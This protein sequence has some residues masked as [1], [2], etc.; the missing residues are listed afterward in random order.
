MSIAVGTGSP[1]EFHEFRKETGGKKILFKMSPTLLPDTREETA[2]V[3]REKCFFSIWKRENAFLREGAVVEVCAVNKDSGVTSYTV[4]YSLPEG[5][6]TKNV[7]EVPH[8]CASIYKS[9]QTE[10]DKA[11]VHFKDSQGKA[12]SAS[13]HPFSITQLAT[14]DE[15]AACQK[16]C[17]SKKVTFDYAFDANTTE[18]E[19]FPLAICN[20]MGSALKEGMSIKV[21]KDR[22]GQPS[23][24][25]AG[26]QAH[27]AIRCAVW[28]VKPVSAN[29]TVEVT[30]TVQ[31]GGV[32]KIEFYTPD[33]LAAFK[34]V[35]QERRLTFVHSDNSVRGE[36]RDLVEYS[37]WQDVKNR[38][39]PHGATFVIYTLPNGTYSYYNAQP[40]V[41]VCNAHP[42]SSVDRT[43]L[44]GQSEWDQVFIKHA[45]L[46]DGHRSRALEFVRTTPDG[47]GYL[48]RPTTTIW[49]ETSPLYNQRKVS[50]S[51]DRFD[52]YSM[53]RHAAERAKASPARVELLVKAG[54]DCHYYTAPVNKEARAWADERGLFIQTASNYSFQGDRGFLSGPYES[55]A[56]MGILEHLQGDQHRGA[57][58]IFEGV[59]DDGYIYSLSSQ[60]E[61]AMEGGVNEDYE[62]EA[63]NKGVSFTI[64]SRAPYASRGYEEQVLSALWKQLK[65]DP[66]LTSGTHIEVTGFPYEGNPG[67]ITYTR[68]YEGL[69]A[70]AKVV[71]VAPPA[72]GV[73]RKELALFAGIQKQRPLEKVEKG[74]PPEVYTTHQVVLKQIQIITFESTLRQIL[75]AIYHFFLSLYSQVF[76]AQDHVMA[77]TL[78]A[79]KGKGGSIVNHA[80]MLSHMGLMQSLLEKSGLTEISTMLKKAQESG[81]LL[82]QAALRHDEASMLDFHAE[83]FSFKNRALYNLSKIRTLLPCVKD[84]PKVKFCDYAKATIH[85]QI[86][87]ALQENRSFLL[88]VGMGEKEQYAPHFLLFSKDEQGHTLVKDIRLSPPHLQSRYS[89]VVTHD[90]G[91]MN[92]GDFVGHLIALQPQASQ[93][94]QK[95]GVAAKRIDRSMEAFI[96][97]QIEAH[98][99]TK[100]DARFGIKESHQESTLDPWALF[101]SAL[102]EANFSMTNPETQEKF[103]AVL[104]SKATFMRHYVNHLVTFLDEHEG[105]FSTQEKIKVLESIK[106]YAGQLK[107]LLAEELGNQGVLVAGEIVDALVAKVSFRLEEENRT[108]EM[109]SVEV[110]NLEHE[111][112]LFSLNLQNAIDATMDAQPVAAMQLNKPRPFSLPAKTMLA[113]AKLPTRLGAQATKEERTEVLKD[114]Q[115]HAKTLNDMLEAG[116]AKQAKMVA[117]ALLKTFPPATKESGEKTFWDTLSSKEE[118]KAWSD[119]L[120][121]VSERF[122]EAALQSKQHPLSPEE[123]FY[124]NTVTKLNMLHLYDRYVT[125]FPVLFDASITGLTSHHSVFTDLFHIK[126]VYLSL[127]GTPLYKGSKAAELENLQGMDSTIIDNTLYGC[128]NDEKSF[129]QFI[130]ELKARLTQHLRGVFVGEMDREVDSRI[131]KVVTEA[132]LRHFRHITETFVNEKLDRLDNNELCAHVGGAQQT[133]IAHLTSEKGASP[134]ANTLDTIQRSF[135]VGINYRERRRALTDSIMGKFLTPLRNRA[136]PP[137]AETPKARSEQVEDLHR[138]LEGYLNAVLQDHQNFIKGDLESI[139]GRLPDSCS[140]FFTGQVVSME[141]Q[142]AGMQRVYSL[143]HDLVV[144][145]KVAVRKKELERLEKQW[146]AEDKAETDS[147]KVR[148]KAI[149]DWTK[150]DKLVKKNQVEFAAYKARMEAYYAQ[151]PGQRRGSPPSYPWPETDNYHDRLTKF[152]TKPEQIAQVEARYVPLRET[153]QKDMAQYDAELERYNEYQRDLAAHQREM[154]YWRA[155][156]M[157]GMRNPSPPEPPQ[158]PKAVDMPLWTNTRFG[159]YAYHKQYGG[160]S[161]LARLERRK[162]DEIADIQ[163]LDKPTDGA[164]HAV[165]LAHPDPVCPDKIIA[166]NRSELAIE[167]E[168]ELQK[169]II[170]ALA[171]DGFL[172][173]LPQFKVAQMGKRDFWFDTAHRYSPQMQAFFGHVARETGMSTEHYAETLYT[174]KGGLKA[175]LDGSTRNEAAQRIFMLDDNTHTALTSRPELAQLRKDCAVMVAK[176]EADRRPA[177]TS[178]ETR[179][180]FLTGYSKKGDWLQPLQREGFTDNISLLL[181]NVKTDDAAF[182]HTITLCATGY[183]FTDE[184][185]SGHLASTLLSRLKRRDA[186][187]ATLESPVAHLECYRIGQVSGAFLDFT[188]ASPTSASL[189]SDLAGQRRIFVR[190]T[191]QKATISHRTGYEKRAF[192]LSGD[193]TTASGDYCTKPDDEF[194][195]NAKT[196]LRSGF[197]GQ[198]TTPLVDDCLVDDGERTKALESFALHTDTPP[199]SDPNFGWGPKERALEAAAASR[200]RLKRSGDRALG[201]NAMREFLLRSVAVKDGT[202]AASATDHPFTWRSVE[203]A[204]EYI[205]QFPD[206]LVH[207]MTGEEV[208]HKLL[209]TVLQ[210][211]LIEKALQHNPQFFIDFAAHLE[212]NRLFYDQKKNSDKKEG[213]PEGGSRFDAGKL[214]LFH[215]GEKICQVATFLKEKGK[216]SDAQH[217][218]LTQ[219]LP[220]HAVYEAN[221]VECTWSN[222]GM[223]QRLFAVYLL[224]HYR[225]CKRVLTRDDHVQLLKAHA[226]I[227]QNPSEMGHSGHLTEAEHAFYMTHL[228]MLEES[229]DPEKEETQDFLTSL[230][231]G[232]RSSHSPKWTRVSEYVYKLEEVGGKSHTLDLS[233]G[234][235]L[236]IATNMDK[237]GGLPRDVLEHPDYKFLFGDKNLLVQPKDCGDGLAEY[238]WQEHGTDIRYLIRFQKKNEKHTVSHCQIFQKH[239]YKSKEVLYRFTRLQQDTSILGLSFNQNN[240]KI[241]ELIARR[242]AW[243]RLNKAG[244]PQTDHVYLPQDGNNIEKDP[245]RLHIRSSKITGATV[246]EGN[247][248]KWVVSSLAS[249][250]AHLLPFKNLDNMLLLSSDRRHVDEIRFFHPP[251]KEPAPDNNAEPS[252]AKKKEPVKDKSGIGAENYFLTLRR[253]PQNR[254]QWDVANREGWIWQLKATAH[255]EKQFGRNYREN[256][257]HLMNPKTGEEE[258]W[259]FPYVVTGT[260]QKGSDVTYMKK[261]MDF[262]DLLE[263][264]FGQ[265]GQTVN[266]KAEVKAM[267]DGILKDALKK[268]GDFDAGR[269]DNRPGTMDLARIA[270]YDLYQSFI[271]QPFEFIRGIVGVGSEAFSTKKME[272]AKRI[273]QKFGSSEQEKEEIGKK[274]DESFGQ[275]RG[276][277][278]GFFKDI[279]SPRA[280]K[281]SKGG[282][283]GNHASFFYLA[284]TASL[285]GDW[286]VASDYLQRMTQFGDTKTAEELEQLEYL[287]T[288]VL[289]KDSLGQFVQGQLA[290]PATLEHSAFQLKMLTSLKMV[291]KRLETQFHRPV[292]NVLLQMATRLGVGKE[293]DK[294]AA[295]ASTMNLSGG[296][297]EGVSG[298]MFECIYMASLVHTYN[299][300][301][302]TKGQQLEALGLLLTREERVALRSYVPVDMLSFIDPQ[303]PFSL[304]KLAGTETVEQV[305]QICSLLGIYDDKSVVPDTQNFAI[306]TKEEV[307]RLM[308]SVA[309]NINPNQ[310]VDIVAL[311]K[312]EGS[313]P[314]WETVVANFYS[315]I[316]WIYTHPNLKASELSFLLADIPFLSKNREDVDIARRLIF[317]FYHHLHTSGY[318]QAEHNSSTNSVDFERAL[319][320]VQALAA[321]FPDLAKQEENIKAYAKQMG[322]HPSFLRTAKFGAYRFWGSLR[323]WLTQ[324]EDKV[325]VGSKEYANRGHWGLFQNA[326]GAVLF[327]HVMDQLDK[328]YTTISVF[329]FGKGVVGERAL[330]MP[331]PKYA[332]VSLGSTTPGLRTTLVPAPMGGMT[333]G[334]AGSPA[335]DDSV[336]RAATAMMS[337]LDQTVDPIVGALLPG[338]PYADMAKGRI[339]DSLNNFL[340]PA[341]KLLLINPDFEGAYTRFTGVLAQVVEAF[342]A[343]S[344]KATTL[345]QFLRSG[346]T[347]STDPIIRP[348]VPTVNALKEDFRKQHTSYQQSLRQKSSAAAAATTRGAARAA[349]PETTIEKASTAVTGRLKSIVDG[350]ISSLSFL[351]KLGMSTAINKELPALVKTLL[352]A[353]DFEAAYPQFKAGLTDVIKAYKSDTGSLATDLPASEPLK[354]RLATEHDTYRDLAMASASPSTTRSAND[355]KEPAATASAKSDKP[356]TVK[357]LKEEMVD[358]GVGVLSKLRGIVRGLLGF[359]LMN[360]QTLPEDELARYQENLTEKIVGQLRGAILDMLDH[361]D[362]DRGYREFIEGFAACAEWISASSPENANLGHL[363]RASLD[364]QF[365]VRNYTGFDGPLPKGKD[366]GSEAG[367]GFCLRQLKMFKGHLSQTFMQYRDRVQEAATVKPSHAI[368]IQM[369]FCNAENWNDA[370]TDISKTAQWSQKWETEKEIIRKQLRQNLMPNATL[371]EMEDHVY[372]KIFEGIDVSTEELRTK[373]S[374]SLKLS[375]VKAVKTKIDERLKTLEGEI[376]QVKKSIDALVKDNAEALGIVHLLSVAH[377]ISRIEDDNLLGS[378]V[379]K[380]VLHKYRD[381]K[382][383][384]KELDTAVT[385]YMLACTERDQLI[386]AKEVHR[387]MWDHLDDLCTGLRKDLTPYEKQQ[388][389]QKKA[390]G[391]ILW[392]LMSHE[393]HQFMTEGSDRLRYATQRASDGMWVLNQPIFS[394]KYLFSDYEK[395]QIARAKAKESIEKIINVQRR[396]I[397]VTDDVV[398]LVKL[399]NGPKAKKAK[400][401]AVV[402]KTAEEAQGLLKTLKEGQCLVLTRA[403]KAQLPDLAADKVAE[404]EGR[405]DYET[406]FAAT[407]RKMRFDKVR[408]GVGKSTNIFPRA[409]EILL[410]QGCEPVVVTTEELVTQLRDFMDERAFTFKFDIS[411]G[412]TPDESHKDEVVIPHLK[413]LKTS[414]YALQAQGRYVLTTPARLAFIRNKEKELNKQLSGVDPRSEMGAKAFEKLQLM[415]EIASYFHRERTV[416][417][418]DEDVNRLVA[419]EYNYA[420]GERGTVDDVFYAT[421]ERF[422]FKLFENKDLRNAIMANNLRGISDVDAALRPVLISLFKDKG[423]WEDAGWAGWEKHGKYRVDQEQFIAYVMGK[424]NQLPAN[425]QSDGIAPTENAL[426]AKVDKFHADKA[427][428]TD[429]AG[430]KAPLPS[431]EDFRER[432]KGGKVKSFD[433]LDVDV[434]LQMDRFFSCLDF[435]KIAGGELNSEEVAAY[436]KG[437]RKDLPT[438][439]THLKYL[440]ALRTLLM[441]TFPAVYHINADMARG[442]DPKNHCEV[443]PYSDGEPKPNHQFGVQYEYILHH[444]LQ[445]G[446]AVGHRGIN[447]ALFYRVY[448]EIDKIKNETVPGLSQGRTWQECLGEISTKADS[449]PRRADEE[450]SLYKAFIHEDCWRARLY[451]VR[452]L[453]FNSPNYMKIFREQVTCNSQDVT[454]GADERMASGTGDPFSL[455]LAS[456]DNDTSNDPD[457]ITAETLLSLF[458]V[459]DGAKGAQ[460][461]EG[462]NLPV[463]QFSTDDDPKRRQGLPSLEEHMAGLCAKGDC[464][465]LINTGFEICQNKYEKLVDKL[466][467]KKEGR[468]R[469]FLYVDSKT[470][471]RMILDPGEDAVA[472]EYHPDQVNRAKGKAIALYGPAQKRGIEFLLPKG[473]NDFG[474]VMVD[475]STSLDELAQALWRMRQLGYGQQGFLS[476]DTKMRNRIYRVTG[477]QPGSVITMGDVIK[478]V[479]RKTVDEDKL[480]HVKAA[481]FAIKA[482]LK[483][484][485]DAVLR[486]PYDLTMIADKTALIEFE[487]VIFEAHRELYI[488][489]E[490]IDWMRLFKPQTLIKR[491]DYIRNLCKAE[492]RKLHM[493]QHK[494]RKDFGAKFV[495]AVPSQTQPVAPK[496]TAQPIASKQ[497][498][499]AQPIDNSSSLLKSLGSLFT[500]ADKTAA[501]ATSATAA[502]VPA[503]SATV[504]APAAPPPAEQL[505][506][507]NAELPRA[508]EV[509][510]KKKVE[511]LK[512]AYKVVEKRLK[513]ELDKIEKDPKTQ[514]FLKKNLPEQIPGDS[515]GHANTDMV[516]EMQVEMEMET[517][518][519]VEM[520]REQHIMHANI[521][522]GP[523]SALDVKS[524][525]NLTKSTT[526]SSLLTE[527]ADSYEESLLFGKMSPEDY[528]LMAKL[529]KSHAYISDRAA[530]LVRA[531]GAKGD[532]SLRVL[533]ALTKKAPIP[534]LKDPVF[535]ILRYQSKWSTSVTEKL[536]LYIDNKSVEITK[537]TQLTS[538]PGTN[539][540]QIT[541]QDGREFIVPGRVELNSAQHIPNYTTRVAFPPQP[542]TT[543]LVSCL[544]VQTDITKEIGPHLAALRQGGDLMAVGVLSLTSRACEW[545]APGQK[546]E[547]LFLESGNVATRSEIFNE[548]YAR[549]MLMNKIILDWTHYTDEEL[550][551]FI[552]WALPE[553]SAFARYAAAI[554]SEKTTNKIKG[555]KDKLKNQKT[556]SYVKDNSKL[557]GLGTLLDKFILDCTHYTPAEETLFDGVVK[558]WS[559]TEVAGLKHYLTNIKSEQTLYRLETARPT[560]ASKAAG[561]TTASRA[562]AAPAT[563]YPTSTPGVGSAGGPATGV[564]FATSSTASSSSKTDTRGMPATMEVATHVVFAKTQGKV[565]Y[566]TVGT[567]LHEVVLRHPQSDPDILE[568][569]ATSTGVVRKF[570]VAASLK[571]TPSYTRD[572]NN[573]FGGSSDFKYSGA[574]A[575]SS[576]SAASAKPKASSTIEAFRIEFPEDIEYETTYVTTSDGITMHKVIEKYQNSIESLRCADGSFVDVPKGL[577][578]AAYENLWYCDS[579]SGRYHWIGEMTTIE[580]PKSGASAVATS[581]SGAASVAASGSAASARAVASPTATSPAGAARAASS[582]AA[583]ASKTIT[584]SKID[585][586]YNLAKNFSY[587]TTQNG[588]RMGKIIKPSQESTT[589]LECEDG[590]IIHIPDQLKDQNEELWVL[591]DATGQYTWIGSGDSLE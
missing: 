336:E 212:R 172:S 53:W 296:S 87:T 356:V 31:E 322:A 81:A 355:E 28:K 516:V 99:K 398:S 345:A 152:Y 178:Y 456:P 347:S 363:L 119:V 487:K 464:R 194:S 204:L 542:S 155:G 255:L 411:Y 110:A 275:V 436:M 361:E 308:R 132:I 548:D 433:K 3:R 114:V 377:E 338:S 201:L 182:E 401:T 180:H 378:R 16:M 455:N 410:E 268:G 106:H 286:G 552:E 72:Y 68:K 571:S 213:R 413:R 263:E 293:K 54:E 510:I 324:Q 525:L 491:L 314:K 343:Y 216:I 160:D 579:D 153:L 461:L 349:V 283:A 488:Q 440:G 80:R 307:A 183:A 478:A 203:F 271:E 91:T 176:I 237:R 360:N 67:K 187:A 384:S 105:A 52:A 448:G 162:Q 348:L 379:L 103:Q 329:G 429:K 387:R 115:A 184:E 420:I 96:A 588:T 43:S 409:T 200:D 346:A 65:A 62:F 48:Y 173:Q 504:P 332:P 458:T 158:P 56:H 519:Q 527:R 270:I 437:A 249:Q 123:A 222:G 432:A 351:V 93:M 185:A 135:G 238:H 148:D 523:I 122:F 260:C 295:K 330:G 472:I 304:L 248:L 372:K 170:T 586:S 112:R 446:A 532:P 20:A 365:D 144:K 100:G 575:T 353:P 252:S 439:T 558:Q 407:H 13:T 69:V 60:K 482:H 128:V 104:G 256:S 303:D 235:G 493:M 215:L 111:V 317:T 368:E 130:E 416:Y 136:L 391:D 547:P 326:C 389:I 92:V 442:F 121:A 254:E 284:Y 428:W 117:F 370:F 591:D 218:A 139:A 22:T 313:Y 373:C 577:R 161:P 82:Q 285:R 30:G 207:E 319:R 321:K 220:T 59:N 559:A 102:K 143:G 299:A 535:A 485:I 225:T 371:G 399:L 534:T 21:E 108:L 29:S 1:S 481:T 306:P 553:N 74:P 385:Q 198:I 468:D 589:F 64:S 520:E 536:A 129:A 277:M 320:D 434:R 224:E 567:K 210:P 521:I 498:I 18:K 244:Q 483:K 292:S 566:V 469:Q 206:E 37:V 543:E 243:V 97:G 197:H 533:V 223:Y 394:R 253:N 282:T 138:D 146:D 565:S 522:Q 63:R 79:G 573:F 561:A 562:T 39:F 396:P 340:P 280:L 518:R 73:A 27:D 337:R 269:E 585:F 390:D 195:T 208:Q 167:R 328:S 78:Y 257:L 463:L 495:K 335:A 470:R 550:A 287:I 32:E 113:I 10:M 362:F 259:V 258:H 539:F 120:Y 154:N 492:L 34:K 230:I 234:E 574:R 85:Q 457:V 242:G 490:S 549:L 382:I 19:Q 507:E 89:S 364:P 98:N 426:L 241:E 226:V 560:K 311:H 496:T 125:F 15:V 459:S 388:L 529:G 279:L 466:R 77:D 312:K 376:G 486:T 590:T 570:R 572:Y 412:L 150:T 316:E 450:P 9:L 47:S 499:T 556:L 383:S 419:K 477:K 564:P 331:D 36:A 189:R 354:K 445:Y 400:L 42:R 557:M 276:V 406:F 101:H 530:A 83:G 475:L 127:Y 297:L 350:A 473:K 414:L 546:G 431:L 50:A 55:M 38:N 228:P 134:D 124:F 58:V 427:F 465:A 236:S 84:D 453:M 240:A 163:A 512:N 404:V 393:I 452:Y 441:Q 151:A 95:P 251:S 334:S 380:I 165:A 196:A 191:V 199:P 61:V 245:I 278:D 5:S 11:K 359:A 531:T 209:S 310:K 367:M 147:I 422:V 57:T 289:V 94:Q 233:T 509:Q 563:L 288:K 23:W 205:Y 580:Y 449:L 126:E 430:V 480:L 554:K 395:K 309:E 232:K 454:L 219:G 71:Q 49:E 247:Q 166:R 341:V 423:F 35:C 424:T 45:L 239:G 41:D 145:K 118:I 435:W 408:M 497:P 177:F 188:S 447:E 265:A 381:G 344:P 169:A 587:V 460:A 555:F 40:Y 290:R 109:E 192:M 369:R 131:E 357:S 541:L 12:V 274:I 576:A 157:P 545:Y 584:A 4:K 281:I 141:A 70:P 517:E 90:L 515:D 582:G 186:M 107:V 524:F 568:C 325:K 171:L 221:L 164:M 227:L 366:L 484:E 474:V 540:C 142:L 174:L 438:G 471:S 86:A 503:T 315:Y 25:A 444:L 179:T 301:L 168:L 333:G 505:H 494:F 537:A 262:V 374:R 75:V 26:D 425:V 418:E 402:P 291:S 502:V 17:A 181:T 33:N 538:L 323:K 327:D 246:G 514:E 513:S 14:P 403:L 46:K 137:L 462:L 551:L 298:E 8:V 417:L 583:A 6:Q 421:Y 264:M 193:S 217:A 479:I 294:G 2:E 300:Q 305:K 501:P 211:E 202:P 116:K 231:G 358:G 405:C 397:V 386:K 581:S 250:D 342:S 159:D 339:R 214:F 526:Y 7:P 544:V 76:K 500:K 508:V 476:I 44:A 273:G 88:P 267:I 443:M 261:M 489:I 272:T 266:K 229:L 156:Q 140:A 451:F 506:F 578:T 175:P 467:M 392:L 302:A 133:L 66:T 415:K 528:G 149:D 569:E 511:A 51:V 190:S 24:Y 375:Q 318:F 352:L